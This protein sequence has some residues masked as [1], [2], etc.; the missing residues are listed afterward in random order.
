MIR[1]SGWLCFA[2]LLAV[3]VGGVTG[4]TGGVRGHGAGSCIPSAIADNHARESP[5]TK[6]RNSSG[7]A[8]SLSLSGGQKWLS[9]QRVPIMVRLKNLGSAA[10][11]ACIT[12][13]RLAF[14]DD[15]REVGMQYLVPIS[16]HFCR[17]K[18]QFHEVGPRSGYASTY[19]IVV[20]GSIRGGVTVSLRA[21][22]RVCSVGEAEDLSTCSDRLE[23][24]VKVEGRYDVDVQNGAE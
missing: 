24:Q 11:V 13:M 9:G 21:D 7:W 22:V 19:D 20:P 18:S 4:G 12:S 14:E 3:V 10:S 6:R 8:L 23:D 15:H 17:S 16:A 2:V 5:I 1:T